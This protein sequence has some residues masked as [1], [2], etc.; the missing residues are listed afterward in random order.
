MDVRLG[1]F[2]DEDCE[3]IR[4]HADVYDCNEDDGENNDD[5][6]D[7]D[8]CNEDDDDDNH[9]ECGN[10]GIILCIKQGCESMPHRED[11]ED[12]PEEDVVG[13][14]NTMMISQTYLNHHKHHPPT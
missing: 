4:C 6:D 9:L 10:P 8:D 2:E 7:E 3:D 1:E 11:G 5:D 12:A 14:M 13:H